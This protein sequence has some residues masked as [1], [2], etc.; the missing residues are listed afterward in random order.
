MGI[1]LTCFKILKIIVKLRSQ[2]NN[3]VIL[4]SGVLPFHPETYIT[5]S[6]I[7]I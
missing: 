2:I 4:F 5:F 7:T 3:I 6:L 1:V